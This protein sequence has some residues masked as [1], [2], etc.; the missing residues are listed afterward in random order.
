MSFF[1]TTHSRNANH[2][3]EIAFGDEIHDVYE[4]RGVIY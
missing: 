4:F 3:I 2:R 1:V